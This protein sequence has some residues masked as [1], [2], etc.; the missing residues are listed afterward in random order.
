M[1]FRDKNQNV[2]DVLPNT[3]DAQFDD[4]AVVPEEAKASDAASKVARR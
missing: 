1:L 3:W 2:I 4:A